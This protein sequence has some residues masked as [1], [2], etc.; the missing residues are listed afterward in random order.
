MATGDDNGDGGKVGKDNKDG[1]GNHN[2]NGHG[3]GNDDKGRIA[4][5]CAS[6]VQCHGR[7]KTLPP[8]PWT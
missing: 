7:G 2:G 4:S 5:L 3:E 6:D 8:P 1:N